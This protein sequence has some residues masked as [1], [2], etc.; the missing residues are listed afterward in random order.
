[1]GW[2]WWVGGWVGAGVGGAGCF[3]FFFFFF[4]ILLHPSIHPKRETY[5]FL[6]EVFCLFLCQGRHSRQGLEDGVAV[7]EAVRGDG[8]PPNHLQILC[9]HRNR[10]VD[11]WIN[12]GVV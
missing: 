5:V 12:D 7:E 11:G 10:W 4:F 8:V 9:L 1:M 3:F 2:G 6:G